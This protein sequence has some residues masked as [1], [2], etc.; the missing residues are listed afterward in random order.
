MNETALV[1][2]LESLLQTDVETHLNHRPLI[3]VADMDLI[4][5]IA[6]KMLG[7]L[8]VA[9]FAAWNAVLEL[10]AKQV[11]LICPNC[12]HARKCKRRPGKLMKLR[13]LGI[14]VEI[15]KLYMECGHC[16]APG[17][18][19]TRVLTGLQ[20]GDS[21]SELKLLAGYCA[22]K[23]SYREAS[24]ELE[25]HHHHKVER[26]QVRRMALQVEDWAMTFA[27]QER[28]EALKR[29][30]QQPMRYGVKRLMMQGDGGSVRTGKLVACEP[31]DEGYGK[32]TPKTKK[33][34]RKRVTHNRE[35]ITLDIR[36]PGALEP[37][38]LDVVVPITA[39]AG[40]RSRR[41]L[42]LG[43][44]CGLG[45]NT[46]VLGLGD[47]GSRLPQSFDEAFEA[48]NSEYSA[49]WKHVRDYVEGATTVLEMP[50]SEI[51]TWTKDMREAIWNRNAPKRDELLGQARAKRMKTLPK[52]VE[53]CPL[54]ALEHYVTKNWHRMHAGR[55]KEMGVDFVSAR[56]E[57]Q[58]RDRTKD[59]YVIAG[60]WAEENIEG[61]ATL[62][63][64]IDE[65]R[66]PRFRNWCLN[67][68]RSIFRSR[69]SQRLEE[70]HQ[71]DQ[72][73]TDQLREALGKEIS[74][75]QPLEASA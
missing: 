7:A 25:T 56:A 66:W 59:R 10:R 43:S 55:F 53:K 45:G 73:S 9:F 14:E 40:E 17:I 67:G 68:L 49:D 69:F 34:R 11:A 46:Q 57:A 16:D 30:K 22:A 4:E 74:P 13:V 12:G 65:G 41:M 50:E 35:I 23:H 21:S 47:L 8:A 38:G 70:A 24:Q 20:S 26:T 32:L 48:Y 61:K 27:E 44:R 33:P 71:N 5:S 42:A 31:G 51:E 1:T 54:H 2:K 19:I 3:D 62:L 52:S 29:I 75:P 28:N 63:S 6:V 37:A 36:E 15:P 64:I 60:A 58:V 18:S 39:K 72:L